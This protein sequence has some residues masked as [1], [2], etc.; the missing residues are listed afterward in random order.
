MPGK[1]Q[2]CKFSDVDLN[3][4]FFYSLKNDYSEFPNWFAKK[5]TAGEN[6]KWAI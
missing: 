2:W 3:D 5:G 1:F 6:A 4:P